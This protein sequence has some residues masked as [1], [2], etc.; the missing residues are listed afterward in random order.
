METRAARADQARVRRIAPFLVLILFAA[1]CGQEAKL[2]GIASRAV[3]SDG[4]CSYSDASFDG[5]ES[6]NCRYLIHGT[7]MPVA[8]TIARRLELEGFAI[9]CQSNSEQVRVQ[10]YSSSVRAQATVTPRKTVY[11]A[12]GFPIPSA[13]M[14]YGEP[15]IPSGS[16]L[17][18]LDLAVHDAT[19]LDKQI[20]E[21]AV[22]CESPD[23]EPRT[24]PDCIRAWNSDAN[25]RLHDALSAARPRR[26]ASVGAGPELIDRRNTCVFTFKSGARYLMI[27]GHWRGAVLVWTTRAFYAGTWSSWFDRDHMPNAVVESDGR[28]G[29]RSR[30]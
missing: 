18:R 13:V 22:R 10:G 2:R 15:P 21:T 3:A 11:D 20:V 9:G 24:L 1:G 17:V 28:L 4:S 19:G 25:A 6:Y 16:V 5:P 26:L 27:V 12:R 23:A 14:H 7:R 8:R 29:L 30:R